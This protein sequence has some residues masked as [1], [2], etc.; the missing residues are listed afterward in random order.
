MPCHGMFLTHVDEGSSLEALLLE[1]DDGP[2][3]V[4]DQLHQTGRSD[5]EELLSHTSVD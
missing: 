3:Q 5:Q 4:Q 2:G 1:E